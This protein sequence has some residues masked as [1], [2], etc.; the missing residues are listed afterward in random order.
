MAIAL[1]TRHRVPR[2]ALGVVR[3]V[4]EVARRPAGRFGLLVI[5]ALLVVVLFTP[6]MAPYDPAAQHLVDRLQG[7]SWRYP[8]G[9]DDLRR[10][11]LSRI[12]YGARVALGVAVPAVVSAVLLGLV[13]GTI[14]G[15][16]GGRLDNVIIVI[17]DTLQ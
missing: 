5:A 7:P 2:A 13:L 1:P 14:A 16:A 17:F 8:L 4:R 11:L 12:F 3:L 9:T 15:Y 10:D 6:W